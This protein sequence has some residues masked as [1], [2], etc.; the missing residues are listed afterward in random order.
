MNPALNFLL[1]LITGAVT[2]YTDL[3]WRLIR[4]SHLMVIAIVA[5]SGYLLD[6][7][8]SGSLGQIQ[9]LALNVLAGI[10]ISI[11][12]YWKE[13]WRAGDAKLFILYSILM[14]KTNYEP[15]FPMRCLVFFIN[16]F[17]IAFIYLLLLVIWEQ[18]RNRKTI[19]LKRYWIKGRKKIINSFVITLTLSWMLLPLLERTALSRQPF[20]LCLVTYCFYRFCYPIVRPIKKYSLLFIVGGLALRFFL[21]PEF[22]QIRPFMTFTRTLIIYN[23]IFYTLNSLSKNFQDV[24]SRVPFAPFLWMGCALSYSSFLYWFMLLSKMGR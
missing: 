3:R 12:M 9:A 19:N 11:I 4:N 14:P 24:N 10:L 5:L 18:V 21:T 6:I 7:V 17:I 13:S 8:L 20:L 23:V 1:I 15:F 2:S 22:F 16:V